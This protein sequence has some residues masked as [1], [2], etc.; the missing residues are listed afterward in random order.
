VHTFC[1]NCGTPVYSCAEDDNPPTRSL[2]IG[3]LR[4]RTELPPKKQIWCVSAMEWSKSVGSLPGT[5][6]Q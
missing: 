6:R 2:R 4:E 5:E 3:C 1:A